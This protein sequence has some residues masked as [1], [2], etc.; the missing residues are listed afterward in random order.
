MLQL[1]LRM[2]QKCHTWRVEGHCST[3][4]FMSTAHQRPRV[5]ASVGQVIAFCAFICH[6]HRLTVVSCSRQC[7]FDCMSSF[8]RSQVNGALFHTGHASMA[9]NHPTNVFMTLCQCQVCD[10]Q[11]ETW[12]LTDTAVKGGP[13]WLLFVFAIDHFAGWF[14]YDWMA[15]CKWPCSSSGAEV[16]AIH[17]MAM[18]S[19]SWTHCTN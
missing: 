5:N 10:S 16:A 18:T 17:A 11:K 9:L 13:C 4:C 1:R 12:K 19:M 8:P 6:W 7:E 3:S 2:W 15:I 14:K